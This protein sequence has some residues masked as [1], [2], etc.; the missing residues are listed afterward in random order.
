MYLIRVT[1]FNRDLTNF[2]FILYNHNLPWRINTARIWASMRTIRPTS[3]HFPDLQIGHGALIWEW[4]FRRTDGRSCPL[5]SALS[6]FWIFPSST[7]L[8]QAMDRCCSPLL[9]PHVTEQVCHAELDHLNSCMKLWADI[10]WWRSETLDYVY[11]P[12]NLPTRLT[13]TELESRTLCIKSS[14]RVSSA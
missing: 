2:S 3:R 1:W 13:V 5:H 10:S 6:R 12:A 4:H 7:D 11:N 14:Q 8:T 9:F